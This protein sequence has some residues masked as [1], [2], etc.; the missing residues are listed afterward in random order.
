M[1]IVAENRKIPATIHGSLPYLIWTECVEWFYG[2]HGRVNF[3]YNG[4]WALLWINICENPNCV[5]FSGMK[6]LIEYMEKPIHGLKGTR[7]YSE[8]IYVKI[9][10]ALRHLVEVSQIKFKQDLRNTLLDTWNS[11]FTDLHKPEFITNQ[12][13]WKSSH[14]QLIK[15]FHMN[16]RKICPMF[17]ALTLGHRQKCRQM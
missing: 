10:I 6:W 5:T 16:F 14:W 11:P 15:T 3:W 7:F 9:W 13:S 4:N 8:S 17:Q 12:Y 1:I 2:I